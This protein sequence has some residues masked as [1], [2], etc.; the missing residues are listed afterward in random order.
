MRDG[1]KKQDR[2]RSSLTAHTCAGSHEDA[3]RDEEGCVD[4]SLAVVSDDGP[5][6]L[7]FEI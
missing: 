4:E 6:E 3:H 1:E 5:A 7:H 2:A